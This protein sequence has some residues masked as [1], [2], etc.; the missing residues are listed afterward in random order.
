[1]VYNESSLTK[2]LFNT[3]LDLSIFSCIDWEKHLQ[4]LAIE[5]IA[6]A[7]EFVHLAIEFITLAIEFVHLAVEFVP[8]AI[9]FVAL[10]QKFVMTKEASRNQPPVSG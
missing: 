5:F 2:T 9:K 10:A 1:M 3:M 4:V 8:W 7:I 6:F